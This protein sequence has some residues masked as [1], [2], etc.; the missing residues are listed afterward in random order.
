MDEVLIIVVRLF[1]SAI[2]GGAVGFE[3][4]AHNRPAGFRTHILVT[5]GASLLMLVS[6]DMGPQADPSRIAAQ[7]VS[8]IGFLGAG[9]ILRTGNNIEGLTTAASL[10]VCSAIGLSIGNG[11]YAGGI[12]ATLIVLFFL[13]RA[14]NFEKHI[15]KKSYKVMRIRG[16][17]KP[18]FIGEIGTVLGQHNII[19]KNIAI[20]ATDIKED[21]DEEIVFTLKIPKKTKLEDTLGSLYN[22]K[23]IR[24]VLLDDEILGDEED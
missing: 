19:I 6:L 4:E 5:V 13:E 9:T 21:I 3:R 2:L 22:I 17:T 24:E 15:N 18:G 11:Y 20:E 8:G 10:W 16:R 1:L 12:I 7:V 14:S 23:G